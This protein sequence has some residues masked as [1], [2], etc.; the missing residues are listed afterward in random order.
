MELTILGSG[1]GIPSLQKS[2]PGHLIMIENEPLLFDSGSGTLARLLK[3]GINYQQLNHVFY[4]HTHSDHTA[5]LIPLLQA[6]RTT[7]GYT[8]KNE[9]NLYGPEGFS[10][11]IQVMA[12]IFGSWLLVPEFPLKVY[13][14]GSD[15]LQ[16]ANWT[17]ATLP[18]QHSRS[19]IGYRIET[20]EGHSVVYSGDTDVCPEI[21]ELAHQANVLILEC[22]FPDVKK[23]KGHLTPSEAAQIAAQAECQH[24]ILT[25]LYPPFDIIEAEIQSKVHKIFTGKISI[26]QDFMKIKI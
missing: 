12:E 1:C 13:D 24:L 22:S 6:L 16:F 18:M 8:R 9:I 3:V 14:L 19:A 17:V 21:I 4:T 15:R 20:A 5:D 10:D 11:F 25:H 23:M 2:A 7:P 26:A